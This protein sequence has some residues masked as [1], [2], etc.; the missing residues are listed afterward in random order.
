MRLFRT[1]GLAAATALALA[2]CAAPAF[3]RPTGPEPAPK[4]TVQQIVDEVL[5]PVMIISA[6]VAVAMPHRV[7]GGMTPEPLR[8]PSAW[9]GD[10]PSRRLL[11][12]S[13]RQ[14]AKRAPPGRLDS[15]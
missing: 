2:A 14:D 9:R 13:A 11:Q 1:I 12:I 15:T 8:Q 5:L 3:A 10:Q 4:I 7:P 6:V